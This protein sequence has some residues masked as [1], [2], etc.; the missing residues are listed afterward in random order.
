MLQKN[1]NITY[2]GDENNKTALSIQ[3]IQAEL[4]I[5]S[6]FTLFCRC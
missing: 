3:E 2:F 1:L 4:L 5:V 6:Q